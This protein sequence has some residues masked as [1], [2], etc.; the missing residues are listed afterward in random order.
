[1]AF[2]V[3]VAGGIK[4]VGLGDVVVATKIYGYESGKAEEVFTP[5]PEVGESTYLAMERA[6][7][8]RRTEDWMARLAAVPQINR[9][10]LWDRWPQA[11]KS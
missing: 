2:F 5:R 9:E 1:M 10:Y 4:D 8:E 7:A 3:G 6:L 11:R